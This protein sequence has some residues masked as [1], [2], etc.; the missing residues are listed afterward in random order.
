MSVPLT[1]EPPRRWRRSSHLRDPHWPLSGVASAASTAAKAMIRC[2]VHIC[3]GKARRRVDV[4]S[5]RGPER[6]QQRWTGV[7]F[8]DRLYCVKR[9]TDDRVYWMSSDGSTWNG[10]QAIPGAFTSGS[11]AL[12]VYENVLYCC[13]RAANIG[14]YWSK[15][16]CNSWI[17]FSRVHTFGLL[18]G[19]SLAVFGNQLVCTL[20]RGNDRLFRANFDGSSWSQAT[21][22]T[23]NL[24]SVGE[25][26]LCSNKSTLFCV[27]G[28]PSLL[29][30][31]I[32]LQLLMN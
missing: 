11:P 18:S 23:G 30:N 6:P 14:L 21:P 8:N 3:W 20:R 4:V 31:P 25:Q 16:V 12:A 22:F 26:G 27:Y 29:T 7:G 19:P 1:G 5:E 13:V 10:Y 2:T 28:A 24:Y 32:V 17:A 15:F 9:G